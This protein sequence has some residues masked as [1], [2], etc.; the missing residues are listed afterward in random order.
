MISNNF[1][2][3]NEKKGVAVRRENDIVMKLLLFILC[4][5]W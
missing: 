2:L 4:N 5:C 3:V 1:L